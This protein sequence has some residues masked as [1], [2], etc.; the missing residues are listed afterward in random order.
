MAQTVKVKTNFEF[1]AQVALATDNDGCLLVDTLNRFGYQGAV[2]LLYVDP[3][4][5][6]TTRIERDP[7]CTKFLRPASGWAN[8]EFVSMR[9]QTAPLVEY[10]RPNN[11]DNEME[12]DIRRRYY[13]TVEYVLRSTYEARYVNEILRLRIDMMEKENLK[14]T[15]RAEIKRDIERELRAEIR[16]SNSNYTANATLVVTAV[17]VI[18]VITLLCL[19][20]A[21][22][23]SE[24]KTN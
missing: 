5:G 17:G 24:F 13:K 3:E 4:T 10:V 12:R 11:G 9:R 18:G 20:S 23:T 1:D 6:R 7:S 19:Y 15:L 16:Q 22:S 8:K 21:S 2:A 14:E